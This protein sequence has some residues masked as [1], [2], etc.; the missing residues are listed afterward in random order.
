MATSTREGNTYIS[1]NLWNMAKGFGSLTFTCHPEPG[2]PNRNHVHMPKRTSNVRILFHLIDEFYDLWA[3]VGIAR[4]KGHLFW[5][6]TSVRFKGQNVWWEAGQAGAVGQLKRIL[7]TSSCPCNQNSK[8]KIN[9]LN[10]TLFISMPA[11]HWIQ[12]SVKGQELHKWR[13]WKYTTFITSL[14]P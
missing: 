12:P 5:K 14:Q 1:T 7:L 11:R 6:V 10:R 3:W 8:R 4:W 9:K 2:R 13:G